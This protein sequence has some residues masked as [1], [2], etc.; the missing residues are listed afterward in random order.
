MKNVIMCIFLC[1]KSINLS[2]LFHQPGVMKQMELLL[3]SSKCTKNPFRPRL[4]TA[5]ELTTLPRRT[6]QL[7]GD[8]DTSS[9]FLPFNAFGIS[10][11]PKSR[12]DQFR[13]PAFRTQ[14]PC[15]T[16]TTELLYNWSPER[17]FSLLLF[18]VI[19]FLHCFNSP[20]GTY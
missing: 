14:Q 16:D 15:G 6:T 18:Y 19:Y 9:H 1:C 4:H 3:S 20:T 5:G 12:F 13:S 17:L 2:H 11:S 8:G 10:I 7:A